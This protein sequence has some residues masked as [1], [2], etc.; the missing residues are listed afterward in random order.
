M[1]SGA[2]NAGAEWA[3]QSGAHQCHD[4]IGMTTTTKLAFLNHQNHDS[5][6][7][8]GGAPGTA[9]CKGVRTAGRAATTTG[10]RSRTVNTSDLPSGVLDYKAGH[11]RR[12]KRSRGRPRSDAKDETSADR[13]RTQVRLAQRAYRYRRDAAISDLEQRVKGFEAVNEHIR[14]EFEVLQELLIT[15][16][17]VDRFPQVAYRLTS[18]ARKLLFVPAAPSTLIRSRVPQSNESHQAMFS[19]P[20]LETSPIPMQRRPSYGVV[21][22]EKPGQ[23]SCPVYAPTESNTSTLAGDM[24][25]ADPNV[26]ATIF[27]ILGSPESLYWTV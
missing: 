4:T 15:E 25:N 2:T 16:G 27:G 7:S 23:A 10:K 20:C 9:S 18:I 3:L 19:A 5:T 22:Q 24:V 13:R 21:D 26:L 8:C 14:E 11:E 17:V 1:D 6:G 12:Q